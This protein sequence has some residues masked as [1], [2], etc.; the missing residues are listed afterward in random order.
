MSYGKLNGHCLE[1]LPLE[2]ASRL[3]ESKT[4]E[5][6]KPLRRNFVSEANK[7]SA[8]QSTAAQTIKKESARETTTT[9]NDQSASCPSSCFSLASELAGSGV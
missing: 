4:N 2:E 9:T 8:D 7:T 1:W 6:R 5:M 3:E